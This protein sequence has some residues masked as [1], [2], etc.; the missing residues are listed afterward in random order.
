MMQTSLY[1][2]GSSNDNLEQSWNTG[3][4]K[5]EDFIY[6]IFQDNQ[7]KIQQPQRDIIK[8]SIFNV[9]NVSYLSEGSQGQVYKADMLDMRF[10]KYKCAIKI[11][12][13]QCQ[14]QDK[15]LFK[16]EIDIRKSIDQIEK[17]YE[18][19]QPTQRDE[20]INPYGIVKY[21]YDFTEKESLGVVMEY[22][23]ETL[24]SL[25]N[26][27]TMQRH[28][29]IKETFISK[30]NSDRDLCFMQLILKTLQALNF[31]HFEDKIGNI[32]KE[33][34]IHRD[35]KPMNIMIQIDR[36][37][38]F[39]VKI[40]DL[41]G[42]SKQT[43]DN[44]DEDS[45]QGTIAF[46]SPEYLEEKQ[47]TFDK[48]SDIWA[49]GICIYRL[50]AIL[51]QDKVQ[52]K[53][54]TLNIDMLKRIEQI[55]N[56]LDP[57]T[58]K[59]QEGNDRDDLVYEQCSKILQKLLT[60]D[61]TQRNQKNYLKDVIQLVNE[62]I[63]KLQTK[64]K[65]QIFE[66]E[67][68]KPQTES[69]RLKERCQNPSFFNDS[70]NFLR[71]LDQYFKIKQNQLTYYQYFFLSFAGFLNQNFQSFTFYIQALNTYQLNIHD[72]N[73]QQNSKTNTLNLL[74]KMLY[75][76]Q[77]QDSVLNAQDIHIRRLLQCTYYLSKLYKLEYYKYYY[78]FHECIYNITSYSDI[79]KMNLLEIQQNIKK[80]L[81]DHVN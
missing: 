51:E 12:S 13:Q 37:N 2:S 71:D 14:E 73:I 23:N 32:K 11:Q 19:L 30:T 16:K 47:Y 77:E 66:K 28:E 26:K 74:K 56:R 72:Q 15:Q 7:G 10:K 54:K 44:N 40:I 68:S 39:S 50:F 36:V 78:N 20:T 21:Y 81:F 9:F 18:Q 75:N 38:E 41:G 6:L 65:R 79:Q 69:L 27:E 29:L 43:N 59:K 70:L 49:I 63:Q 67:L 4:K 1:S 3:I 62:C 8:K 24:E 46:Y 55:K 76:I 80:L 25:T 60:K 53:R 57:Q 17:E 35:I 33:A 22:C 34:Y 5:T 64:L 42:I 52:V 61:Q 48:A 31:L 45:F 58:L